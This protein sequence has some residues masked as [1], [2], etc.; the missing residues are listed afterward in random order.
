MLYVVLLEDLLVDRTLHIQ[1][2]GADIQKVIPRF[3]GG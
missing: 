1:F 3:V 2:S